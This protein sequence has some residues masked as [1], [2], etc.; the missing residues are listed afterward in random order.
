MHIEISM[1]NINTSHVDTMAY[2]FLRH[3]TP[4]EEVETSVHARISK[5]R[6]ERLTICVRSM[7]FPEPFF[8]RDNG[9]LTSVP[10]L[11]TSVRNI[12]NVFPYNVN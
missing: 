1:S 7:L 5:A 3:V 2:N 4:E 10:T 9:I 8:V 11:G 6:S 12:R